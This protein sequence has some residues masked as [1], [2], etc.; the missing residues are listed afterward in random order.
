ME[1]EAGKKAWKKFEQLR[2]I[3]FLKENLEPKL[4]Y[5]LSLNIW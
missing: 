4:F 2:M 1:N 3:F 5:I